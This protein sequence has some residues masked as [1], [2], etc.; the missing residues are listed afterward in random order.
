MNT[1]RNMAGIRTTKG[2]KETRTT[3]TN[4]LGNIFSKSQKLRDKGFVKSSNML[5]GKR[6]GVGWMYLLK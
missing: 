3:T 2:T 1:L 6:I 5:I 4:S